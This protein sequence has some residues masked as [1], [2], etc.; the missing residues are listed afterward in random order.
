MT[1]SQSTKV[2]ANASD[3]VLQ[4]LRQMWQ[5]VS[6][7]RLIIMGRDAT[8][9]AIFALAVIALMVLAWQTTDVFFT[10]PNMTNMMRQMVTTGLLSLGML[11]V[12]LTGGIDLSVGSMVAFAAIVAAGFSVDK[13]GIAPDWGVAPAMLIGIATG[14]VYGFIN[15][16]LVAKFNLAPFVV[17]LAT[18]TTIRGLTY[19][20]SPV[21][22]Q[23][24]DSGFKFLGT[25][26][27]GPVPLSAILM[28][29]VFIVGSVFLN[30]TPLGRSVIA[31]GGNR[32]TVRLAGIS[33]SR[34]IITAY[35]ISGACA[36]LAGVLIASRVGNV[37]PSLGSGFE[38]NAIAAC[39][40]GGADL[41]GGKGSVRGTVA[42]VLVLTLMNTLLSLW[43]VQSF[44]QDVFKGLMIISVIL[45]Q[46]RGRN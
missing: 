7:F 9:V 22:V 27:F 17:T 10:W 37:Q 21:P 34:G 8:G 32:E 19:V 1:T 45:V 40:I 31:I 18:M 14:L 38:L 16:S 12:I 28:V 35:M 26:S 36:A 39:V 25:Y 4:Y 2:S 24:L 23:P 29:L 15:G 20:Y 44:Y 30:R 6:S 5:R 43:N 3:R 11:C 13:I 41:A 46:V 42:G 33:V